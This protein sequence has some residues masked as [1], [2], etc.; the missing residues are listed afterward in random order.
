MRP[1]V[2]LLLVPL[3]MLGCRETERAFSPT[4][5]DTEQRP[6]CENDSRERELPSV[7]AYCTRTVGLIDQ[8]IAQTTGMHQAA[9]ENARL[10]AECRLSTEGARTNSP[11]AYA[12]CAACV[13]ESR[14]L[15]SMQRDCDGPCMM[16]AAR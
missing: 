7:S 8:D 1:T 9:L 6:P 4:A 2:L 5:S 13:M 12:E 10:I 11:G 14:D 16:F 15:T 3:S